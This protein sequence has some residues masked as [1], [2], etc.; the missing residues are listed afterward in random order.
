MAS[1]RP[2]IVVAPESEPHRRRED[3]ED[4]ADFVIAERDP[5]EHPLGDRHVR[6]IGIEC[7]GMARIEIRQRHHRQDFAGIDVHDQPVAALGGEVVDDALQFLVQDVLQSHIDRQLHRFLAPAQAVVEPALDPG[8]AVVVDPG[9]ADRMRQQGAIGVDAALFMLE[10]QARQ[11][12]LVDGVG[13]VGGQ[14]ALDPNKSFGRCQLGL[15][16]GAVE[17][18][19]CGDELLGGFGSVESLRG[20]A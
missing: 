13:L 15:D 16:R 18:R 5:V 12:Q 14:M 4:R 1:K 9:I 17:T 10:L 19:Q 20:L 7:P 6:M 11:T 2:V 8:L 3:L